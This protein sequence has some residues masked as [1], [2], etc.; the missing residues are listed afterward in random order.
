M[1]HDHTRGLCQLPDVDADTPRFLARGRARC[2]CC[3]SIMRDEDCDSDS[4]DR[5]GMYWLACPTCPAMSP[6][7]SP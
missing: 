5:L 7:P 3:G 6:E 4:M 2:K 1:S